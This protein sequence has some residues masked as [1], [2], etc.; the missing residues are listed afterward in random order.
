VP[1]FVYRVFTF[2]IRRLEQ[3]DSKE[4]FRE[5][6]TL[7][8][9]LRAAGDLPSG[10]AVRVIFADNELHAEDLLSQ[11]REGAPGVVGDE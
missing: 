7:A 1:Y 2:P 11:V 4:S 8:K 9:A 10:C 3:I 5:A 6:S